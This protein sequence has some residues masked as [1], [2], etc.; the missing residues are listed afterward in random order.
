[1]NNYTFNNKWV[2]KSADSII[3]VIKTKLKED[4]F[5]I[6]IGQ[7]K[8]YNVNRISPI[9]I[10]YIADS[11]A[12]S[13]PEDISIEDLKITIEVLKKLGV[14]NSNTN[15]LKEK[16]PSGLYRKRTPLFGILSHSG[17]IVAEED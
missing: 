7:G 14:F 3:D 11:R 15:L 16:I 13:K 9:A 5:F 2:T 8:K 12:Q 1:M 4:R 6:G 17:I 10:Y